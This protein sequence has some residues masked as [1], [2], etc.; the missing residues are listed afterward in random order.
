MV[1]VRL[2]GAEMVEVRRRAATSG[3]SVARLLAESTLIGDRYTLGERR[4]V[5]AEL[6][7]ARRQVAGAANNLNQLA[8]VANST[9]RV[10]F[11]VLEA[12]ERM[13]RAVGVLEDAAGQLGAGRA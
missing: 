2:T 11:E 3:V 10:P 6:L 4:A 5:V 8:R 12:A 13:A 9:G 1:K 7:A